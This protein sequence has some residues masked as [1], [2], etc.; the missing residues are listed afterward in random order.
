MRGGRTPLY[1]AEPSYIALAA[2]RKAQQPQERPQY[3]SASMRPRPRPAT[4]V[5]PAITLP[6]EFPV[7]DAPHALPAPIFKTQHEKL[8]AR[9]EDSVG[10]NRDMSCATQIQVRDHPSTVQPTRPLDTARRRCWYFRETW[11][12]RL[13]I[14]F[15]KS[16][17]YAT[18]G[19]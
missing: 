6:D 8:S 17:N 5:A 7:H 3:T 11:R 10:R 9:A 14:T 12:F 19:L 13:P 1:G 2:P 15:A 18:V 16:R 4:H